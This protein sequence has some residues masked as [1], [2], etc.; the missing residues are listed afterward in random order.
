M[1]KGIY[2]K[3]MQEIAK[4]RGVKRTETKTFNQCLEEMTEITATKSQ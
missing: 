4:S 2:L 3:D 1:Q